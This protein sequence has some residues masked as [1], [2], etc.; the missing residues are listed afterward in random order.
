MSKRR[1]RLPKWTENWPDKYKDVQ[2]DMNIAEYHRKLK[3]RRHKLFTNGY[4]LYVYARAD[5]MVEHRFNDDVAIVFARNKRDAL[6]FFKHYYGLADEE[7][8]FEIK[9]IIPE[10]VHILTDY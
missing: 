7:T 4:K 6:K 8:V 2:Y 5:Q 9:N 10:H 1:F 3:G